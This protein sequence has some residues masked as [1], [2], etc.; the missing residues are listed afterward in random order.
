MGG[1][2][3]AHLQPAG[4]QIRLQG[5]DGRQRAGSDAG[6][7]SVDRRQ[8]E[9]G[10]EQ[11]RDLLL[12]QGHREHASRRQVPQEPP[13][14]RHQIQAFLQ[15]EDPGQTGG[16]VLPEAVPEE[17]GGADSPLHPE[18]RQGVLDGEQRRLRERRL[19]QAAGRRR[20]VA[21]NR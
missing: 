21:G 2:Q 12:G 14:R 3:P 17:G 13:A 8:G 1:A 7:R 15:S 10:A 4:H 19:R 20:L 11:R 18:P 6:S 5:G 9:V 16:D